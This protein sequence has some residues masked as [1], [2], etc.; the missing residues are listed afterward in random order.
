MSFG[1]RA[2]GKRSRKKNKRKRQRVS[3]GNAEP[4]DRGSIGAAATSR[5]TTT[6]N[7]KKRERQWRPFCAISVW[8]K[9]K[10]Q[11]TGALAQAP[12]ALRNDTGDRERERE[13]GA[14]KQKRTAYPKTHPGTSLPFVE[15]LCRLRDRPAPAHN[16]VDDLS[17]P[18]SPRPRP[19]KRRRQQHQ[20]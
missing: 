1:W 19:H 5:K 2:N 11:Q 15:S 7:K 17:L 6:R 18:P 14:R 16:D 3:T 9:K 13:R 12:A 8:S 10:M 20:R 4:G